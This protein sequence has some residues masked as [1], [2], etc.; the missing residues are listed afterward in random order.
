MKLSVIIPS[1]N[2]QYLLKQHLPAVA[3]TKPEEIIVVDDASTDT[4]IEFITANWPQ[5]KLVR[6]TGNLGFARAV[7]AGVTAARGDIVVLFNND[8]APNSDCLIDLVNRFAADPQLFSIG[9][10]ETDPVTGNQ[11]GKSRGYWQRGL[12]HH[13]QAPDL[14]AGSTFWTFAAAA[15]Y[16]KSMWEKLGGLDAL[17]RPAYWEDID[18][19]YRAQKQGWRVVFDPTRRVVHRAESTMKP[20]LGSRLKHVSFKNQLLFVWKNI[21]SPRLMLNHLLWLPYNIIFD[22]WGFGLALLQLPEAIGGRLKQLPSIISDEVILDFAS[23]R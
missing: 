10:W 12:V 1:Y 19:S 21:N 6:L 14:D 18:L 15:A 8:V 20:V 9:F 7:N 3:A 5:I 17:F 23:S 22:P 16:R 13:A 2:G 4:S 11:R